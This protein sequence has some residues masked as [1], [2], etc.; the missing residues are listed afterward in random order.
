MAGA[1]GRLQDRRATALAA[2]I[3]LLAGGGARAL[4]HRAVDE[5]AGLA[6][7]STSNYFRTRASLIA[8]VVQRLLDEDL[9]LLAGLG[10]L[11][12]ERDVAPF[13]V[14]YV[15]LS[16][17]RRWTAALA[18]LALL[19]DPDA[20]ELAAGRSRLLEAATSALAGLG[21]A[22][23]RATAGVLVDLVDGAIAGAVAY[24][25]PTSAAALGRAID[26]IVTAASEEPT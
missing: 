16:R 11:P 14:G 15:E 26:A 2:A 8:G 4:T 13:L 21:L 18:R 9:A 5:R 25:N 24:G 17:T 23:P 1:Q 20:G 12:A 7:G 3:D 10:P 19:A 22:D 6:P